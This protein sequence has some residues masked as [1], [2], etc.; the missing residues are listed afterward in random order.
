MRH[1]TLLTRCRRT[2]TRFI[3]AR[4]FSTQT[5][6]SSIS[7][8]RIS[9]MWPVQTSRARTC[10]NSTSSRQIKESKCEP[11]CLNRIER[12]WPSLVM[13]SSLTRSHH[14]ATKWTTLRSKTIRLWPS[15]KTSF[16]AKYPYRLNS[17]NEKVSRQSI[18]LSEPRQSHTL[19]PKT[20]NGPRKRPYQYLYS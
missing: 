14:A 18:S 5:S 10:T 6:A 8:T 11:F 2:W 1:Y 16:T 9:T 17:T 15:S 4:I 3:S 19:C 7:V 20:A 12:I 13:C